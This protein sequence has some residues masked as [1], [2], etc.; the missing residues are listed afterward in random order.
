MRLRY[1]IFYNT[2]LNKTQNLSKY[3]SFSGYNRKTI[4]STLLFMLYCHHMEVLI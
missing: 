2:F 1:D 3:I 4:D